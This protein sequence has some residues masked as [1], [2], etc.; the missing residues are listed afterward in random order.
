MSGISENERGLLGIIGL[1]R[2]A[3]KAVIGV[4]MICDGLKARA[5]RNGIPE[6]GISDGVIIIEASD[7]SENTH[8]RVSDRCAYYKVRHIRIESDCEA[9][10]RAVGKSAV[11]A[12]MINDASFCRAIDKKLSR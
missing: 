8:K 1:C 4:P 11:G 3:G 2:G 6:S 12:V 10:G 7:T 9:L 5:Q